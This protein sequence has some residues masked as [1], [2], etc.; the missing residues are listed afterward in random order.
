MLFEVVVAVIVLEYTEL[1]FR[2]LHNV[3]GKG[4]NDPE[5]SKGTTRNSNDDIP[6]GTNAGVMRTA[7]RE[8]E[9]SKRGSKG[10][11]NSY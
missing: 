3:M 9:S 7:L 6:H 2:T 8:S 10:P 5:A 4:R 11:N 1:A